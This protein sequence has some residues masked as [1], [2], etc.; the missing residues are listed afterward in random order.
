[1]Q[2]Q[3]AKRLSKMPLLPSDFQIGASHLQGPERLLFGFGI[4]KQIKQWQSRQWPGM[5]KT[6]NDQTNEAHDPQQAQGKGPQAFKLCQSNF[7]LGIIPKPKQEQR[8]E[9][10]LQKQGFAQA[11]PG[12]IMQTEQN[13]QHSAQQRNQEV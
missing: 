12:K 2:L 13:A 7:S 11:A 3:R 8:G 10:D 4:S 9:S 1:M 6:P 5:F